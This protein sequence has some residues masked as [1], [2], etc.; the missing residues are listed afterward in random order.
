[1]ISLNLLYSSN[2]Y[3]DDP[4]LLYLIIG[5]VIVGVIVALIAVS[6]MKS[7][8]KTVKWKNNAT[9]YCRQ[10]SF[11]LT[12]SAEFFLYSTVTRVAR[13]KDPPPNRRR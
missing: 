7:K 9:D 6:V 13:P 10:G 11:R 8:L 3:S 1:M 2:G 12:N 4:T 5:S